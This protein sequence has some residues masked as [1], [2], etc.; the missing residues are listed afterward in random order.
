M[1]YNIRPAKSIQRKMFSETFRR[2]AVFGS[3]ESYRYIGFGSYYFNDFVLFHKHL[4]ITNMLS[5]EKDVNHRKRFEFNR[6]YDCIKIEFDESNNVLP[7]LAWDV[8]TI[9]WL[10]Y[11]S[12]LDQRV[13]TD[14]RFICASAA[15]GSILIISVNVYPDRADFQTAEEIHEFRLNSVR[16]RVGEENLPR[17]IDGSMLSGWGEAQLS[18]RIVGN[19]IAQELNNRNG[20]RA[21]GNELHYMQLFN[22][23][24]QDGAKM[25]TTGG[26]LFDVGQKP[27][28]AAASFDQLPFVR[29]ENQDPYVI[30][31]PALTFKEIRD[32]NTQLP[33]TRP[34]KLRAQGL[35]KD[36]LERYSLIYRYFPAFTEAE[37]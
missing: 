29:L 26:L 33:S 6:P 24:Y 13:L 25:M 11:E 17:D 37:I 30:E 4:G 18:R 9:V 16:E 21:Q 36:E 8:R 15:P 34:Q 1:N 32:L 14:V 12:K 3:V 28:V 7:A 19:T 2:L 5:I 31:V 20:V 23:H 27:M 35:E 22:F 10:D